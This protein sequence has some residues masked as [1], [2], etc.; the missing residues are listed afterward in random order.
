MAYKLSMRIVFIVTFFM[1]ISDT[2]LSQDFYK[3]Y[4]NYLKNVWHN[5]I[6]AK[7]KGLIDT[8]MKRLRLTIGRNEQE[9]KKS[10][11]T[12]DAIFMIGFKAAETGLNYLEQKNELLLSLLVANNSLENYK[13]KT[14]YKKQ[15]F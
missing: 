11:F 15:C 6:T 2:T 12:T 9:R 14:G 10:F 4:R 5:D 7:R 8:A 3:D 1:G 13:S